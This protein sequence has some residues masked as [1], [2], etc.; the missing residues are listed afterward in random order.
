MA[1]G[2]PLS[3]TITRQQAIDA[4]IECEGQIYYA[5][6]KL[7]ISDNAFRDYIDV[8]DLWPIVKKAREHQ[9]DNMVDIGLFGTKKLAESLEAE[10][11]VALKACID[12]LNRYGK[13]RGVSMTA[14]D[15]SSSEQV[16]V[17]IKLLQNQIGP[18]KMPEA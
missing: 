5:A 12:A 11:A 9:K 13:D 4:I 16:A 2:I 10:P 17:L 15:Q 6:K 14:N 8:E 7:F 1:Y 18:P 3:K